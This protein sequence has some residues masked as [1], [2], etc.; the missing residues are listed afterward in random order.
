M[1]AL[2]RFVLAL[3]VVAWVLSSPVNV[4]DSNEQLERSGTRSGTRTNNGYYFPST[5]M[6]EEMLSIPME[7]AESMALAS[8]TAVTL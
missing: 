5:L 4:I 1:V 6:A 3:S 7:L 2:K 8:R